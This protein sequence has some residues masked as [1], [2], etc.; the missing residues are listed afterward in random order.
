MRSVQPKATNTAAEG[1]PSFERGER[2]VLS[3]AT[4]RPDLD[5]PAVVKAAVIAAIQIPHTYMTYTASRGLPEL[6]E[7]VALKL[8]ARNGVAYDPESEVLI[9]A[10]THEALYVGLQ[11]VVE[12]GDEVLVLDPSWVAYN[13]MIGLAGGVARMVTL[14]D[15]RLDID[16]LKRAITPRTRA[17][18]FNNPNNP[19]GTVFTREELAAVV[20]LLAAHDILAIVD[21]IYE[22][23]V[24]D[25]RQHVSLASLPGARERVLLINGYSKAYAMTGWRV[26]YAAGP[27]WL[28]D[29]MLIIHQHLISSPCAFAQKGAS[30]AYSEAAEHVRAMVATYDRRRL[31]L[32]EALAAVPKVSYSLPEG[33]CFYFLRVDSGLDSATLAKTI[34]SREGLVLTPGG[35][36]GPSGE[37][38]LRFSFAALPEARVGE[39][40]GRL[41]AALEAIVE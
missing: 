23:F 4:A 26:G 18:V 7:S 41:A 19:T 11:A 39:A 3:L 27:S 16:A 38:H 37:R 17:F 33:A 6:R 31:L 35:A 21:E 8:G 34:A 1:I 30:V 36:F 28:I 10:G 15:N 40:V 14:R 25:G 5:T 20:D 9:T 24:Y 32:N 29:R 12:P 22:E 2:E 13:G